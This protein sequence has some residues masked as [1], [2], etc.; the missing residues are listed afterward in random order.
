MG[1]DIYILRAEKIMNSGLNHFKISDWVW[2]LYPFLA[3]L[4]MI[5]SLNFLMGSG[6]DSVLNI[7]QK[8]DQTTQEEQ[9]VAQ[10]KAKLEVLKSVDRESETEKLK[11]LLIAMPQSK[12]IWYL[13]QAIDKTASDTGMLVLDFG[14]TVGDV[15]EASDSASTSAELSGPVDM[16]AM[17]LK[18]N[19]ESNGFDI[20][21]NTIGEIESFLPLVKVT[22]IIYD[23]SRIVIEVEGAW[24]QFVKPTKNISAPLPDY[25]AIGDKAVNDIQGMQ[26]LTA[27]TE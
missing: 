19:Y 13:L 3:A 14:G 25:K 20:L 15:K 8:Q 26:D 27:I 10:L 12:K 6:N 7:I 11:K 17:S 4:F 2:V 1:W 5:I 16:N 18:I 9:T 21:T 23:P 22:H 24:G